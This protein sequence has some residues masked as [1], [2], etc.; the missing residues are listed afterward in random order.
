MM[1]IVSVTAPFR[2][3]MSEIRQ[4]RGISLG[5]IGGTTIEMETSF[6][7]L[8]VFFVFLNLDQH[9]G[10]EY[11]LLWVP[12]LLISVLFHELAHAATIAL[13]GFGPSRVILS[14]MGGVTVNQ[15]KARPWQDLLISLAGP[16]GSFLLSWICSLISSNLAV[17]RTD[18]MLAAL[19]PQLGYANL[20]W[21]IF[22]LVPVYPLDGG[23]TARNVLRTFL[24]ERRSFLISI[25]SSMAIGAAI[26]V[27][28][29]L[30][31]WFFLAIVVAMMVGQN[32]QQWQIY[33]AF[34]RSE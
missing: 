29:L 4:R 32:F 27:I 2:P 16:L 28:A 11:A 13:L 18:R 23:Q 17:A 14:G 34:R 10:I 9:L 21:G 1:R 22:N 25:W 26:A 31:G 7:I 8:V 12:I 19:L 20:I 5:S 30:R 3:A 33:K 15:R 24:S 6:I